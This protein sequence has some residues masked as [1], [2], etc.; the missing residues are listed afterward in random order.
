MLEGAIK[1]RHVVGQRLFI[2]LDVALLVFGVTIQAA[3]N[4]LYAGDSA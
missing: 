1:L 2:L 4:M 3:Q